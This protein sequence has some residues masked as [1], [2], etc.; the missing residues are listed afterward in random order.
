MRTAK[1]AH[2]TNDAREKISP[3]IP[4]VEGISINTPAASPH[5]ADTLPKRRLRSATTAKI[6]EAAAFSP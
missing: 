1:T 4:T 2:G 3:T 5:Y 6:N